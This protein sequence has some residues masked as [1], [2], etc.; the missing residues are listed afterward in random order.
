MIKITE[1]E[2]NM[3]TALEPFDRYKYLI[4][5]V[6]DSEKLYSLI[7]KE[8]NWAL[9]DVE[10]NLLLPIW[11]AEIFAINCAQGN[12][13]GFEYKEISIESFEEE[14]IGFIHEEKLLLNVFPVGSN[15]GFVVDLNEFVRDLANELRKYPKHRFM[16]GF[17]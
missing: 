7:N 9:S 5:R 6:A 10:N 3:V 12:W 2:V 13:A 17:N 15:T 4:K 11:S 8:G 1:Q 14:I 16:S